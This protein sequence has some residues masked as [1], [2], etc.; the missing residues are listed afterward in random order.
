[1]KIGIRVWILI[2]AL[3][4][5]I[6]AISPSFERGI[7]ISSVDDNSTA[8]DN[9]LRQGMKI[10][11]VNDESVKTI[12]DYSN[13]MSKTFTGDNATKKLNINV[14]S[15]N[16]IFFTNSPPEISLETIPH[17]RIKTGLDLSGG[18]RALLKPENENLSSE[19]IADLIS[20]MEKRLNV[21]GIKDVA[22]RPTK[23]LNG[24]NFILVEIAGATPSDIESLLAKQGKF[25]ADVGNI[26]VFEGGANDIGDV[27]K[28]AQCSGIRSCFPSQSGGWACNFDFTIY[29]TEKAAQK[30]ADVTKNVSIDETGNYLKDKLYLYIDDKEVNS[31]SISVDL[32]GRATTQISIQGSGVGANQ[33]E[34]YRAAQNEMQQLQT[35]LLTG[36]LPYKIK[37]VKLDTISPILGDRFVSLLLTAG[38]A[39][40]LV[41]GLIIFIRYRK[42]KES[43]ALILTS[44]SELIMILGVAALINWNLDLLSIAGIL[45]TIGTGVDSQIVILEEAEKGRGGSVKDRIKRALFIIMSAFATS[46]VSLV[47]LWWAGAGLFKGFA[48]TTLIGIT[49]GVFISRPAFAE[50]IRKIDE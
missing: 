46:F 40:M 49:V 33:D 12:S 27:C 41:V 4:L 19:K 13:I 10:Q 22:I 26:T 8:F 30:H 38:A 1:M 3:I 28:N 32:K 2:I 25:R 15:E 11:S 34:A 14:E 47:P 18:A 35:V 7:R 44:F 39:S 21:Y 5:A 45:A 42:I 29:L 24:E 43:I 9:G 36:S 16:I 23:D 48:I 37:I 17:T 20:I 31:L 6:L 50:I